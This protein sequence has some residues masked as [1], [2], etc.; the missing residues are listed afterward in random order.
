MANVDTSLPQEPTGAAGELAAR[1]SAEHPLKLY[2]GWF[3]PFVQR[4]WITL[5]E[6]KIDYQYVETNPYKKDPEFIALNPRGLVPTLAVP[7]DPK[8][9]RERA[10]FESTIICEY[11]DEEY[12]DEVTYGAR[13]MP[14]DPY[15]RARCRLWID[16]IS[17]RI[18][19]AFYKLLQ[20]TPEKAF[21][22]D[23]A[24]KELHEQIRI[25]VKEMDP[26]GPWFMGV[27]FSLVDISL[28]PWVLRLWLVD[29]Y[30]NGGH[31]IPK[32][33]DAGDD[34]VWVRW[35]EWVKVIEERDSIQHTLSSKER[36][37]EAYK[38]YADDTTNSLVGQATREGKRLP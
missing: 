11:L 25:F 1:H 3:C 21:T 33:G 15:D 9:K 8:G 22:L 31:G 2:A 13:L 5:T 20:H 12:T 30:K 7:L 27:H 17:T 10:L 24:R 34:E 28:A 6:K 38:R 18:I 19:P 26:H 37:I 29:H 4:A 14:S 32:E 36:Y 23:Q 35:R 16:H